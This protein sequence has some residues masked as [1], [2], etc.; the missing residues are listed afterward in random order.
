M[1]ITT[2]LKSFL[3]DAHKLSQCNILLS[4]LNTFVF[5]SLC[6]EDDIFINQNISLDLLGVAKTFAKNS[7]SSYTTISDKN[8][9]MKL[10]G[11]EDINYTAQIVLPI[12]HNELDGLLVFFSTDRNY[13]ESNL[14]F[15]RTTKYFT[16][17]LTNFSNL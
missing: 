3:N 10:I 15:A 16:E 4:D 5:T 14:R 1:E 17:K 11:N 12:V 13:L 8:P 9:C 7:D 2:K 6:F